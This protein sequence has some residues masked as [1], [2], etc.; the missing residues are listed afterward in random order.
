MRKIFVFILI[1]FLPLF[2]LL[3]SIE[4]NTFNKKFYLDFYENH[5]IPE[6][7]DKS[8][9]ELD[10]ITDILLEYLKG[11]S[12]EVTLK[13]FFNEKEILH[14]K[15]VKFL[16]KYGII[17]KSISFSL[18]LLT[19]I[20]I[21]FIYREDSKNMKKI[22][23]GSFIWWGL[24]L[25]FFFLFLFDFNKYFTYFHMIFFDNDL[26]LLN[27]ETD[28]LIQMFPKEFFINIFKKIVSFFIFILSIIQV[29]IY[30]LTKK[31]NDNSD[32]VDF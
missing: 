10:S 6:V 20:I 3:K 11:K 31:G 9:M 15:D 2:F 18:S 26:W 19:I 14:M 25:I 24:I 12:D 30:I 28:L 13:P 29:I 5:N 21:F 23:Y 8:L 1:I 22:F 16:F 4:I 27:P 32:Q 7:I 17:L